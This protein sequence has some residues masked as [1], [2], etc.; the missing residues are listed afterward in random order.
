MSYYFA[1]AF[2]TV[3]TKAAA[4]DLCQKT[5]NLLSEKAQAQ[6]HARNMY[7]SFKLRCNFEGVNLEGGGLENLLRDMWVQDI[8]QVRFVYWPQHKLLALC[9]DNYPEAVESLFGPQVAFQNC[10]DQDYEVDVWDSNISI[11]QTIIDGISKAGK[12]TIESLLGYD[13]TNE[14]YAR[15]AAVYQA[16]YQTLD[17]GNWLYGRV[18]RFERIKMSGLTSQEKILDVQRWVR[19]A[20]QKM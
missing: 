6:E 10:T 11:F 7:P 12:E 8:F 3:E 19:Y 4:Y 15:R 2:A 5:V 9:G 18:G 16:A 14:D 13:A 1:M 20:T 17:L